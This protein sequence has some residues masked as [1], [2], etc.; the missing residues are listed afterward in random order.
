MYSAGTLNVS[1]RSWAAASRLARGLSGGS[2][3]RTGCYCQRS[4]VSQSL[5]AIRNV[6]ARRYSVYSIPLHSKSSTLPGIR[7][8]I[9]SPYHP[10]L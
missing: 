1:K 3:R 2:V 7:T 6:I 4:S 9:S 8:A 5:A 10:N